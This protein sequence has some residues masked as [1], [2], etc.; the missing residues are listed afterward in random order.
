MFTYAI[1]ADDQAAAAPEVAE[2]DTP[3]EQ[4]DQQRSAIERGRVAA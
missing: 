1:L 4:S 3:T 2:D